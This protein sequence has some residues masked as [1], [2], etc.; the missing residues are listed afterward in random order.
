ML[1]IVLNCFILFWI[2]IALEFWPYGTFYAL[3]LDS[4]G[5]VFCYIIIISLIEERSSSTFRIC[6]IDSFDGILACEMCSAERLPS[7]P[8]VLR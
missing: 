4:Y 1:L 7:D 2:A 5:L 6:A 3:S 8:I